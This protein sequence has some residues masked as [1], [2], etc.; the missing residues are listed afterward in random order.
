MAVVRNRSGIDSGEIDYNL[1]VA[2]FDR[3][4]RGCLEDAVKTLG[5]LRQ[6]CVERLRE[7]EA[8]S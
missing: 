2:R 6:R 3:M 4:S 1:N 8:E 7:L 5:V